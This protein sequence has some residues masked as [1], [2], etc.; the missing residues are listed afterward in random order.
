MHLANISRFQ[1]VLVA[2]IVYVP[3]LAF[4]KVSLIV[5]Y[6]RIM[7]RTT[8]YKWALY[9]LSGIVCG[10]SIALVLALIFACNPIAKSW[11]VSITGGSCIDRNGVYIA[12]AVTNIITDLA[13][14]LLPVPVVIT[15]QMPRIQKVGLLM[16]FTIGCA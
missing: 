13:L 6:H 16:L 14:I 1:I 3:A 11:D 9:I 10:Y 15:L 2:A 5:L 12:T 4:A 8:L 7:N